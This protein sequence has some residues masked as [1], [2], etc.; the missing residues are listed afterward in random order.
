MVKQIAHE[1]G[2][3]IIGVTHD[4]DFTAASDRT[5]ELADGK[6]ISHEKVFESQIENKRNI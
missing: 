2:Q 5:I 1:F 4:N 6:I 3:W